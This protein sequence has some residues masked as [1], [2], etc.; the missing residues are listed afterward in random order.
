M[1]AVAQEI[2][3]LKNKRIVLKMDTSQPV[4][5]GGKIN[6]HFTNQSFYV[7]L[8]IPI[9]GTLKGIDTKSGTP[10]SVDVD[11]TLITSAQVSAFPEITADFYTPSNVSAEIVLNTTLGEIMGDELERIAQKLS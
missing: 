6:L 4:I 3:A 7:P 8:S 10:V 2:R 5:V 9:K 1:S 11:E